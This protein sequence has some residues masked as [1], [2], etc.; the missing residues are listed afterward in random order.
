MIL[1]ILGFC[2]G[3]ATGVCITVLAC[4]SRSNPIGW[5]D[6]IE[7]FKRAAGPKKGGKS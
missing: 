2:I 6:R 3:L 4:N 5:D 7:R 1:L